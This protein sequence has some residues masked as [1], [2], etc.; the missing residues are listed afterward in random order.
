MCRA[1]GYETSVKLIY[2]IKDIS[3]SKTS[4]TYNGKSQMPTVKVVDRVNKTISDSNYSVTFSSGFKNVGTYNVTVKFKNNY[5]GSKTFTYTINPASTSISS[6]T[7]ASKGFK[8]TWKKQATQTTGYQIQYA[9]SSSFSSSKT[10]TVSSNATT[11]KSIT[12]LSASKKY[13]VR[14]RTYKTVSGKKYYSS[15][16]S[17]KSITTKK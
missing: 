14:V 2:Q 7:A 4:S 13:Y 12:G 10:V 17:S 6:V 16:S 3:L 11:S 9:T 1:C 5:S 15:W 8:L